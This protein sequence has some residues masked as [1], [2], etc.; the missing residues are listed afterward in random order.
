LP[1]HYGVHSR[2]QSCAATVLLSNVSPLVSQRWFWGDFRNTEY[3][4]FRKHWYVE[5]SNEHTSWYIRQLA[6]ARRKP[7]RAESVFRPCI[8][9]VHSESVFRP[10]IPI[11]Y[12]A[13]SALRGTR[14]E[15]M[16]PRRL[17]PPP[18]PRRRVGARSHGR[19]APPPNRFTPDLQ[20]DSVAACLSG[21]RRYPD[22]VAAF[23][24]RHRGRAPG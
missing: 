3:G 4:I 23:L 22:S 14:S 10:C 8:P 21:V 2:V 18:S 13:V 12:S 15:C 1:Q 16:P 5:D 24:N 19:A 9:T 11:V 20:A 7:R 17:G 6:G